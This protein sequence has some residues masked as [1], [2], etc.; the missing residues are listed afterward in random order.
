MK[1]YKTLF[2]DLDDTIWDFSRNSREVYA[3]LY[4]KYD[5]GRWFP[6]FDHYYT[7]YRSYNDQL[8]SEYGQG[9]ITKEELNRRRFTYPLQT[10]GVTDEDTVQAFCRESLEMMKTKSHV[11]PGTIELLAYLKE[12]G[13]R[14]HIISNGFRELQSSKLRSAGIDSYFG[15]LILSEDIMVHKPHREI[16]DFALS[17][18]Q[19]QASESVM[20]G[21]NIETDIAGARNAGID[22][23]FLNRNGAAELPF[24]P[25][26][27]V[28]C[29][30]DIMDIL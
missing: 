3:A 11:V 8:W 16:F 1:R 25:T 9:R 19:S 4:D 12:K 28:A 24:K 20:I 14:M 29:M 26:Y 2:F 15:K 13:Y 7:I 21:D 6:S 17:A 27:T 22:Q 30:A 18:T 10:V 5:Y 23:I